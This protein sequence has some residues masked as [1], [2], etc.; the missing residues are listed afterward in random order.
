MHTDSRRYSLAYCDPL[1]IVWK[2]YEPNRLVSAISMSIT[3]GKHYFRLEHTAALWLL[4]W[5]A[6]NLN[7]RSVAGSKNS[8][9]IQKTIKSVGESTVCTAAT[10]V[11]GTRFQFRLPSWTMPITRFICIQSFGF[12]TEFHCC[13]SEWHRHSLAEQS[14][15]YCSELEVLT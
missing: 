8:S 1:G 15:Q 6:P 9:R 12:Q 10:A 14:Y 5:S 7:W 13:P 4:G 11:N 2:L 3:D